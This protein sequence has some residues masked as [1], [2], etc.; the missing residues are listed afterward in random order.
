MMGSS[1]YN[2]IGVVNKRGQNMSLFDEIMK[3][4]SRAEDLE[5]LSILL[6]EYYIEAENDQVIFNEMINVAAY[7]ANRGYRDVQIDILKA[8]YE[9]NVSAK[10]IYLIADAYYLYSQYEEAYQWIKKVDD[11]LRYKNS[12][13]EAKIL[14][15]L[16]DFN[17]AK[18]LL[19]KLIANYNLKAEPYVVLAELFYDRQFYEQAKTYYQSAYEYFPEKI[20]ARAVRMK[21]VEL[22][23]IKEVIDIQKIE[24]LMLTE[25]LPIEEANE[26]Y[27]LAIAYF[28]AQIIDKAIEASIKAIQ[29]DR[30]LVD[31]RLLLMELYETV[32]QNNEL[33]K[34]IDQLAIMLPPFHEAIMDIA[35][36][37]NRHNYFT[38]DL[39]EKL[40][41]FYDYVDNV[42]DQYRIM[43]YLVNYQLSINKPENAL[44]YLKTLAYAFEDEMSLTHLFAKTY[45]ALNMLDRAEVFY[46]KALELGVGDSSLVIDAVKFYMNQERYEKA[47]LITE[48]FNNSAYQTQELVNLNNELKEILWDKD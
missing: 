16:G 2:G 32:S 19:E 26:Y 30:D 17:Q 41:D 27:I 3:D 24:S 47:Y 44:H 4:L 10:I 14:I 15:E 43:S 31:A 37:A 35:E 42:E 38:D 22:E 13:L 11:N 28:K 45:E 8:L 7:Y 33:K 40:I 21:L 23:S 1:C 9:I 36:I 29:A 48:D 39:L 6:E 18:S 25:D 5:Q 34:T 20:D 46:N 12:L